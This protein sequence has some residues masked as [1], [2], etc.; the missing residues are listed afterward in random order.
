[1]IKRRKIWFSIS[2]TLVV[3]S[4]T[5]FFIWGLK[6]AI[7][8]TGGSILEIEYKDARPE[9]LEI[10]QALDNFG[11]NN[12]SVQPTG[13]R[14]VI[15]RTKDLNENEHQ[16]ILEAVNLSGAEQKRFDS[17]GPVIGKELTEKAIT[18]IILVLLMIVIFIAWSFRKVSRPVASWKY[19]VAA[20][21]A[22][23]HDVIIPVGV[24]SY[25]GH[26]Y[27]IEIDILFVTALLTIL[28]FSVHDTIVVF[29]RIRENLKKGVGSSFEETAE[30]SLRQVVVRSLKTSLAIFLVVLS[31][32]VF[33]ADSTKYF[34][35]TLIMGMFFGA[36]SSIFVASPILVSWH[37][38][39]LSRK[40][41][42]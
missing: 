4:L 19:G 24:F 7:D 10:K 28:G 22:L 36:Y 33:G 31:L 11:F 14:G 20:I 2:I 42:R 41:G 17:I 21:I 15:L 35:L 9:V 25:L 8:F 34:A 30:L 3:L 6:P 1:M 23:A 37:N 40:K 39:S 26:F 12:V 38:F 13:D 32:F 5:S 29:D 18:S 16:A 27:G